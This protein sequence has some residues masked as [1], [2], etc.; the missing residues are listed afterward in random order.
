MRRIAQLSSPRVF[1]QRFGGSRDVRMCEYDTTTDSN[2]NVNLC[3]S[4]HW[5]RGRGGVSSIAGFCSKKPEGLSIKPAYATGITG[6][7]SGRW[8]WC[9]PKVY[10]ATISVFSSE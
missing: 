8:I 5:R 3:Y 2:H 1:E 4:Q 7:S 6:Q 10:Q 9:T